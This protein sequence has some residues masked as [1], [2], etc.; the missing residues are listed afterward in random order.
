MLPEIGVRLTKD[1]CHTRPAL[2]W[3]QRQHPQA[4]DPGWGL[5]PVNKRRFGVL[6]KAEVGACSSDHP[7]L[8]Q[9]GEGDQIHPLGYITE[10]VCPLHPR[11]S[12]L[13]AGVS[14]GFDV[15]IALLTYLSPENGNP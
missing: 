9:D 7:H 1:E 4:E 14:S 15:T 10:Q 2:T 6:K 5:H 3:R 11:A 13:L 8:P 12:S